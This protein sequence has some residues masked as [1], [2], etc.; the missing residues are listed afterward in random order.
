MEEHDGACGACTR[1]SVATAYARQAG[2]LLKRLCHDL[3]LM[4]ASYHLPPVLS[5][6]RHVLHHVVNCRCYARGNLYRN[7]SRRPAPCCLNSTC[8]ALKIRG[9]FRGF[10]L[11]VCSGL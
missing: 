9:L 1:G 7:Q 10:A 6:D 11:S 3:A 5:S 8:L 4:N 2:G